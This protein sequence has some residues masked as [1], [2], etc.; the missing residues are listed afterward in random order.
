MRKL[1]KIIFS[2]ELTGILLLL[3][4]ISIGFA[5]FIENDFGTIAAKSKVYNAGWLELMLLLLVINMTGNIFVHKMYLKGKWTI[6]M[7]HVSFLLIFFGAAITRYIG[8]EG[9]MSIREG[10]TSNEIVTD[11]TYIRVWAED[12]NEQYYYEK[13][14]FATPV[15]AGKF[16]DKFNIGNKPAKIEITDYYSNVAETIVEQDGGVPILWLIVSEKISGRQNMYLEPGEKKGFSEYHISF[17]TEPDITDIRITYD[18]SQL[19]LKA[20]DSIL[21]MNMITNITEMLAPDSSHQLKQRTLYR[22]GNMSFIVKKFYESAKTILTSTSGQEGI[23]SFDAFI[24]KIIVEG[25]SQILPVYGGRGFLSK[26]TETSINGV[27]ITINYGPKKRILPFSIRL[28]DFQLERY[29]GSNSP[30]S[31][32]SEVTVFDESKNIKMPY[33]IYM[34]NVLNYGGYRFFQSSYDKDELGTV[35]SVNHDNAGTIITYIGYFLMILGMF[36]TIFNKNSRFRKLIKKSSKLRE[37][38][39]SEVWIILIAASVFLFANANKTYASD[40]IPGEF[41]VI[42]KG[43]AAKFGKLLIQDKDGRV[44]PLNTLSSEVLRKISRKNNF[45]GMNPEQVFLGM[46][47]YQ[48]KC[49]TI[50]MIKVAHPELE[51]YLG[52]EGKY[53]AFNQIVDL[54]KSGGY[55]LSEYVERAYAKKPAKQNKFDKELLKVDERVNIFYMIYSGAFLNV[56]PVPGEKNHKWVTSADAENYFDGD[57]AL[58]VNKIFS[59]YYETIRKAVET[60]DWSAADEHLGYILQFQEDN[61]KKII[62]PASKIN[63]EILYNKL[64]IFKRLAMYYGLVGFI[65]LILHF[66]N[67]LK[68]KINLEIFVRIASIIIVLLFVMHTA[69]LTIRWYVSGH[70]PWSDGYESMIYIGW[71]TIL[72]GLIFVRHSQITLSVTAILA[73]LILSVAGMSWMDPEITNLVPVLKS[74]W[75]IIHVAIITASYGFLALGAI[76]GFF[77]LILMN[78]KT[79]KN[80]ERLF[81]T[82][83]ELSFIIE[84][85]LIIGLFMLTIGTFLGGVWANESWGRYWGWDPKE[86]W[87]L[88]TILIYSFVAHIRFIPGFKGNFAISF[89]SL[90]SYGS[91]L[92]TYFGVN[93]YL[94][95]LHSYAKGDPVPVPNFVYYTLIVVVVVGV[96]AYISER[97]FVKVSNLANTQS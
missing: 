21:F 60:G 9:M 30:S 29:P 86:T 64:N 13:K 59:M 76:L 89:L 16:K 12:G 27:D 83:T 92:M 46:L 53:A 38:R 26:N 39:K 28:D 24:A 65:L 19:F 44:K 94:S 48:D 5:T 61:G 43:H 58:F 3:F 49:L 50:P 23:N 75:L 51:N 55:K 69:G 62:P 10:N 63:L 2:M 72:G 68:P 20:T 33:R 97:K 74:Y 87:A 81:L 54:H 42:D 70:A 77:N 18:G 35:L 7:F 25:E 82:N 57:E 93:Y 41:P 56:F 95:G 37:S 17:N 22:M 1:K 85:T 79:N 34:N 78:L 66:I 6:L 91:V 32:A 52:I 8:Y 36:F 31:Y 11:E 96:M 80:F 45:E 4:A 88:V 73:S 90:I 84:M 14:V 15:S 67:I 47:V 40:I 71:A